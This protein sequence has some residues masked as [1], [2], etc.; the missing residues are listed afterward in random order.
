MQGDVDLLRQARIFQ[1]LSEDG[2]ASIADKVSD[3]HFELGSPL[4]RQGDPSQVLYIIAEVRVR[5]E[6]LDVPT[7]RMRAGDFPAQPAVLAEL[8]AGDV[9]GEWVCLMVS[10]ARPR[11][12]QSHQWTHSSSVHPSSRRSWSTTLKW[13]RRCGRLLAS[14]CAT[15]TRWSRGCLLTSWLGSRSSTSTSPTLA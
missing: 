11:S 8:G 10:R 3:R 6:R 15:R 1:G 14:V 4:M 5:I 2:L 7:D 12:W 13:V 9:V